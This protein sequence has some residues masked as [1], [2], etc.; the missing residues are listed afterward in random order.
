MATLPRVFL[1][2]KI[3]PQS[4]SCRN[5]F[6][7]WMF[8]LRAE[9]GTTILAA[10]DHEPH[11]AG[12]RLE[13]FGLVRALEAVEQPSRIVLL[14]PS[15]FLRRGLQYGLEAWEAA[16]WRWERFG[17]LVSVRNADL[18]RR[19]QHALEY[20]QLTVQSCRTDPA[21]EI[22]RGPHFTL[23]APRRPRRAKVA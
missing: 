4:R 9:D 20:H 19:V 21:H 3:A 22:L 18:W 15:R 17:Q 14:N 13:L 12:E 10:S 16:G 23:T 11:A 1:Q 6:P 5:L 8:R 7:K 2:T